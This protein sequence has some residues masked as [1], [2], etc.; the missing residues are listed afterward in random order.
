M[1]KIV[2]GLFISLD[3]VVEAPEQWH[4]PYFN[5]EMGEAVGSQMAA[6]DTMLL[7]RHTY[8]E[9]AAY[10]AD[11]G[12]DVEFADVMNDT[13][14]LVASTTLE[15]VDWQNSTLLGEDV[16]QE[17]RRLKE[18][19]GKDISITGSPTLVRSLLR[20]RPARRAPPPR[21]PDR[22][23]HRASA[24]SWTRRQRVPLKLVDVA[25]VQHRR[26]VP[27]LH[28]GRRMIGVD[29]GRLRRPRYHGQEDGRTRDAIPNDD[30]AGR[31]DRDRHPRAGRGRRGARQGKRPP[32]KI[33]IN[34]FTY[35]STIAVMGGDYMVGVSAENRAGAGS[36]GGDE[37]DV[38]I[39]LDTEP[40]VVTLP[41]DFAAALD[42]EPAA[43][44]TFDGLSPSN[45]GWHVLPVEGAK[46]DETRQRRIAKQIEALRE[47][48][49]R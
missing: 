20:R 19:P 15:S 25:D 2:A 45:K 4:F 38:D 26:A 47:G 14:K 12:S 6:A 32:V 3:G 44:R 8:E 30:P 37:V 24:C 39:E 33:T 28:P 41:P 48:R 27:D 40:R 13:P 49:I 1:R 46:T 34:G 43:R 35:R 21:P 7:G 18:E 22:G 31:Q 17:L 9:F 23:R 10:W 29:P 36:P 42:A 16:A 5:D 11:K